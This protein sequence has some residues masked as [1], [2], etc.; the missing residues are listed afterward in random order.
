VEKVPGTVKEGIPKA[1]AEAVAKQLTEAGATV[2][3]K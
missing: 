1:E 2:E 3:I